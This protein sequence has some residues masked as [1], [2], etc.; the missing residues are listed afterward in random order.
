MNMRLLAA[1]ATGLAAATISTS[2]LAWEPIASCAP[3]WSTSPSQYHVNEDGY[4]RIDLETVRGIFADGFDEWE[5][6]CCSAWRATEAGLT[7]GV[8]EDNRNRQNI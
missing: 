8:G 1:L 3:T 5:R 2:A 6:P 4:S 7:S